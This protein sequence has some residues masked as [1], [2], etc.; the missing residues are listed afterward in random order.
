MK[1]YPVMATG[2]RA[3]CSDLIVAPKDGETTYFV[4]LCG[5]PATVKGLIANFL[6]N[7]GISID[8]EDKEHLL[9]RADLG[10][11]TQL[12]KMPSGL[13]HA[14]VYPEL[15]L[16]TVEG[17]NQFFVFTDNSAD[18]REL[19]FRH[20]DKKVD[21]PLHPSWKKWLWNLFKTS[22]EWLVKLRTLVGQYQGYAVS[23]SSKELQSHI[24]EAFK[25]NDSDIVKCMK[26]K[27]GGFHEEQHPLP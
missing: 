9:E 21:I 12:K 15:A 13:L 19:F 25:E 17:E 8:I 6:E 23:Y 16:A 3:Y 27:G 18:K 4:S 20:L 1:L 7:Y 24:S 2:I 11:R 14:L 10:Y 22:D 5:Y 26:Q